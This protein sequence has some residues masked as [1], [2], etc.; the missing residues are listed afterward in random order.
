MSVFPASVVLVLTDALAVL[1]A[2]CLNVSVPR[3]CLLCLVLTDALAVLSA[4][5]LNVSVLPL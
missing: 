4:E 2:E 5:C 3:K 1:S